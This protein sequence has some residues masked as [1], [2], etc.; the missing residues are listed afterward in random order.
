[1][2]YLEAEEAQDP[3]FPN[4][5]K[6]HLDNKWQVFLDPIWLDVDLIDFEATVDELLTN[7]VDSLVNT[8]FSGFPGWVKDAILKISGPIIDVIGAAIDLVD[9]FEEWLSDL[10]NVSFGLGNILITLLA[11]YLANKNPI[12]SLE[13][14]LKIMDETDTG[15]IPVKIPIAALSA[16]INSAEMVVEG[17]VGASLGG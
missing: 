14:P 5:P 16:Q 8:I 3:A 10:F 2:G 17:T 7:L 4:D 9:D 11:D 13:D 1:M 12:I 6:K 15:L